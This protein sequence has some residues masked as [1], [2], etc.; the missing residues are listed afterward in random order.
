VIKKT[1]LIIQLANSFVTVENTL[2]R[3]QA[4]YFAIPPLTTGVG[5]GQDV[6]IGVFKPGDLVALRIRWTD[7]ER[8]LHRY[9]NARGKRPVPP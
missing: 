2:H 4:A 1:A 5:L 8:I 9:R 7:P 6:S 3:N